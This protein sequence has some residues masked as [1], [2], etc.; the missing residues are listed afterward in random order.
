MRH[1]R[2]LLDM[3]WT[4]L[5]LALVAFALSFVCG[6]SSWNGLDVKIRPGGDPETVQPVPSQPQPPPDDWAP[7]W[8]RRPKPQNPMKLIDRLHAHRERLQ[9]RND[10]GDVPKGSFMLWYCLISLTI[11]C[12]R[13]WRSW[14]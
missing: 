6:C 2:P 11:S 8:F 3:L 14:K 10:Q 1:D 4:V 7:P 13:L 9:K 12:L 5:V